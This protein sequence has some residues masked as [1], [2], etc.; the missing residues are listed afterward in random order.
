M[1]IL[2]IVLF[3]TLSELQTIFFRTDVVF[4]AVQQAPRLAHLKLMKTSTGEKVEVIKALA[5][6]WHDFG[7]HLDFDFK[8]E[9]LDQIKAECLHE[10]PTVCCRNMFKHWLKGNG[11]QPATWET[12]IEL[13]EDFELPM[14]VQQIKCALTN[15]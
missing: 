11:R 7:D 10:G 5:P 4:P 14:L 13:L 12:L 8:G 1:A 2:I 3:L 6:N 15:Q 9:K